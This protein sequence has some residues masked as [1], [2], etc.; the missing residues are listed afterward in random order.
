MPYQFSILKRNKQQKKG[1][2][3]EREETRIGNRFIYN[4]IINK[5]FINKM[6]DE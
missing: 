2:E 5:K 6:S 4:N 3:R 1:K